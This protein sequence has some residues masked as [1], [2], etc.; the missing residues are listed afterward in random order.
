[1]NAPTP[2]LVR[3]YGRAHVFA[4]TAE[5]AAA[6][7][8]RAVEGYGAAEPALMEAAGRAAAAL[9]QRW[10]PT[11]R[12]VAVVGSGNN[13]GDALVAL[14]TLAAWGRPVRAV[15][16]ADRGDDAA[17]LRGW[18][19]ELVRDTDLS[20]AALRAA[21]ADAAAL[22]DGV[23]G[24]GARGAPRERQARAIEAL[25]A[26]EAPVV[27]LDL[28]SGVDAR[29][30]AVA[31]AAVRARA[32]VAFGQPKRGCLLPPG[33]DHAGRLVAVEIGFPPAG[34]DDFQARV[35]TPGWAAA[36]RP[37]R[38]SDA[39]KGTAGA[40]LVLAGS[41][42]M[43]GAALMAARAALRTGVGLVRIA[44]SP[45]NRE[46]VQAALPEALFVDASDAAALVA[47][48]DAS[49]AVVA[50]PGLGRSG[51]AADALR[52]LLQT[53]PARPTVL[54]ADGLNLAAEGAVDLGAV[55]AERPLLLTPHPG[56]ME[57]LSGVSRA[58]QATDRVGAARALAE[59]TGAVVL[60]KGLPS[61]VVDPQGRAL[62]DA[63][64]DSDLA[65][66]G[67]G[68]VLAGVCGS[69]AA[70]GAPPADAG[71]LGLYHGGR[72]A[73]R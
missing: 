53:A 30:G 44:S 40:L 70:Q 15:L 27:A 36:H 42:G 47:A 62:I 37:R 29:T 11:G 55:A 49:R 43:A 50:G 73:R 35:I 54:D 64:G 69:F 58:R 26:A 8:R 38:P 45:G 13:G 25:N 39:H 72:A 46:I 3:P 31:S 12:V 28:P 17:L 2:S 65:T 23:L 20:D 51:T 32:T 34:P 4:A 7:D 59:R 21:L 60:L 41:P 52:T 33:R 9:V 19:V 1:M 6:L 68:D 48:A 18:D 67:M 57:R 61:V 14:R 16:A 71:G 22:L 56:E 10:H 5:E 24:T 66:A 63:T